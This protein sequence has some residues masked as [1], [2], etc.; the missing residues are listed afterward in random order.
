MLPNA[1][2]R[3]LP[4]QF[5]TADCYNAPADWYDPDPAGVLCSLLI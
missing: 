2:A 4:S 1:N 3:R 5:T